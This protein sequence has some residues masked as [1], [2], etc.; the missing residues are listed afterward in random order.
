MRQNSM[1]VVLQGF[2]KSHHVCVTLVP[3]QIDGPPVRLVPG[4]RVGREPH[5]EP[6]G[7][8]EAAPG[9]VVQRRGPGGAVSHVRVRSV[10]Q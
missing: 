6:D 10:V 8:Q 1:G 3:G 4:V 7:V 9:R 5:Q 2:Q